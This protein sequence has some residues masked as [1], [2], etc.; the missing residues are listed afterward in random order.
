MAGIVSPGPPP[1]HQSAAHPGG[2]QPRL[3]GWRGCLARWARLHPLSRACETSR[4][5]PIAPA[6]APALRAHRSLR[7][8]LC[9]LVNE[10]GMDISAPSPAF[11]AR[12]ASR[13]C[14]SSRVSGLA[15]SL[16][17]AVPIAVA[18]SPLSRAAQRRSTA[19]WS[20]QYTSSCPPMSTSTIMSS[21]PLGS[22]S[23]TKTIRQ[24]YS[25]HAAQRPTSAP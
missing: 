4:V 5:V 20:C 3:V 16:W 8:P 11:A 24:S 22:G 18:S 13:S 19:C 21:P 9:D 17:A 10:A 6:K 23:K 12:N 1:P 15:S 7:H 25:T 14:A 2:R